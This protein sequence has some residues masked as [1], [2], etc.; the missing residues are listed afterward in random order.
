[1]LAS[2]LHISS[3]A[4][5]P[6]E[7]QQAILRQLTD[8]E[9]D[10]LLHDWRFL[11]RKEQ[12]APPGQW[13]AWTYLG[14]RGAGKTRSGAEWVRERLK[15][16]AG[17]IGLIAPTAGDARD[18]MVEG[19]SGILAVSWANDRTAAGVHLGRPI[20]E[21]SKRRLSWANGAIGT[22]FSAEEPERLRGPQHDTIWADELAAWF[23]PRAA[24]DMAMFGLRLGSDPRAMVATTPKPL[25]I[26]REMV[27]DKRN[28]VSRGTTWSNRAHLA[29]SFFDQVVAKYEGTRLGRQELAGEILEEAE[30]ALWTRDMI[31]HR[32]KAPALLR[33]VVGVD[34][35]AS[36]SGESA[37]C[38]IC[39]GGLGVDRRGYVLADYSARMSPGAWG[40]KVI[41]AYDTFA[42]DRIVAEGNQGG[43]MVAHT[44]QTV[45]PGAPVTTVYASRS[46]QARAEPVAALYE[47]GKVDHVGGFPDLEDQMCTWE[48]LSGDPSPDRLDA[49]VWAMT[50]LAVGGGP[51]VFPQVI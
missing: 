7:R 4:K 38:G 36:S 43:E 29:K 9:C 48:P 8:A 47:Q 31:R 10:Q 26:I 32:E 20:Y 22:L 49:M 25:P 14:G 30:G 35:P 46:K 5:L 13:L 42:A 1:M 34:P 16:G 21:P 39:V 11:A 23:E 41:E 51:S 6:L 2:E 40:G 28:V 19:V 24:W 37:L 17:R 18:V 44:I 15:A 45:R 33:V 12:V 50:E 27:S 3:L